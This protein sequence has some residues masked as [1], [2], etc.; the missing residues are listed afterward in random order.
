MTTKKSNP[1]LKKGASTINGE[2][3][4]T[5]ESK[6]TEEPQSSSNSSDSGQK[7]HIVEDT[8]FAAVEKEGKWVL[9]L[10]NQITSAK[11]FETPEEAEAYVREKPWEL[12]WMM[13]IWIV[14]NQEK[15]Q[16]AK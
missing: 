13:A 14:N 3:K 10:G 7:Y 11:Q 9:V 2:S 16:F 4:A 6:F 5:P 15:F 8:P 1:G 12:I